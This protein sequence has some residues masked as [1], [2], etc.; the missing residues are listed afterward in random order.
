MDCMRML[1]YCTIINQG[2]DTSKTRAR[3]AWHAPES[4]NSADEEGVNQRLRGERSMG[5]HLS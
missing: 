5:L 1:R 4:V 2:I 3:A